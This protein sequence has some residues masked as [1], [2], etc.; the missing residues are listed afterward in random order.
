MAKL[1]GDDKKRFL[2]E[3]LKEQRHLLGK[4]IK[5]FASGD[6]AEAVRLA[7][8]MRVLV[9]ETGNS[10]PLLGQITSNYLQLEIPDRKPPR[11]GAEKLPP[12][13]Q[14]A[15]VM[16]VPISVK[17]SQEGVFLNPELDREAYEPSILGKWWTRQSCLILPGLGGFSRKE[18][19]L[20]LAH[21]EGGAHV[22]I[23]LHPKY[24]Q[25]IESRQLQIGWNKDGV[26]PLN[27]SRY[28]TAQA[29]V[30]LLECLNKNFPAK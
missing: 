10:K 6:L 22:D 5:E 7:I 9:Y 18:I 16:S 23:N 1:T 14:K 2:S 12:G 25:L 8:A 13:L 15:V 3:K 26:S 24:K 19:V 30:E 28:M 29:A 4:S 17:I 21:K 27:L 11:N 20:G